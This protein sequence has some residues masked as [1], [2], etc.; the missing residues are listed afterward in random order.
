MSTRTSKK[1]IL[2][3]GAA[4]G[5]GAAIAWAAIQNGHQVLVTDIDA[6][7]AEAVAAELGD[8]AVG[9]GLDTGTGSAVN[10][11]PPHRPAGGRR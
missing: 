6:D 10:R 5:I 3:T 2:I 7:T 9:F 8:R 11:T 1:V 4:N